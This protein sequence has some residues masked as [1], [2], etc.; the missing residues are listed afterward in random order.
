MAGEKGFDV[1]RA[2]PVVG[3]EIDHRVE[4]GLDCSIACDPPRR[5]TEIPAG[6]RKPDMPHRPIVKFRSREPIGD[7]YVLAG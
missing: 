7:Q 4:P 5:I 2:Q 6:R 3:I 1:A